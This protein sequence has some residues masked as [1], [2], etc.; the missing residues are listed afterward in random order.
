MKSTSRAIPIPP[1]LAEER[2]PLS[3]LSRLD[4][5]LLAA[6]LLLAA[7]GLATVH[8]ASAELPLD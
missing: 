8:S 7:V 6:T 2:R 4:W 1:S 5:G 3:G